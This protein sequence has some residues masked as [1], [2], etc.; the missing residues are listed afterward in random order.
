L[1]FGT[2]EKPRRSTNDAA[3]ICGKGSGSGFDVTQIEILSKD[4]P[5]R[6]TANL[7][8]RQVLPSFASGVTASDEQVDHSLVTVRGNANLLAGGK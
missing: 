1:P 5:G 8:S 4:W 2:R 6:F 3:G 7:D